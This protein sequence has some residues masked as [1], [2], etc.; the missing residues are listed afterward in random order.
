MLHLLHHIKFTS[1]GSR[2]E[3]TNTGQ[4]VSPLGSM[5][6]CR[7]NA[8]VIKNTTVPVLGSSFLAFVPPCWL[9]QVLQCTSSVISMCK[10]SECPQAGSH[11]RADTSIFMSDAMTQQG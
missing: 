10:V 9:L 7:T 11:A 4:T 5:H 2:N 1:E 3:V 6:D 8:D